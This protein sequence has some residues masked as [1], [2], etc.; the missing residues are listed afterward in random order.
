VKDEP[1]RCIE[2]GLQSPHQINWDADENTV[3]VVE[4]GMDE[5]DHQRLKCG[6]WHGVTN[7]SQLTQGSKTSRHSTLN[8]R[9]HRQVT[10]QVDPE[11]TDVHCRST[12]LTQV[13][14]VIYGL[15]HTIE[16]QFCLS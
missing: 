10:I 16:P 8:V 5:C 2:D 4:P 1:C 15:L 9:P 3:A 12:W 11:I 6:C 13:A 14:D 7:L